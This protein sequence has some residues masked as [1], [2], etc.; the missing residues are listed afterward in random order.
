MATYEVIE[1]QTG[2]LWQGGLDALPRSLKV[3]A[4]LCSVDKDGARTNLGVILHQDIVFF[5]LQWAKSVS[6]DP[7]AEVL[8]CFGLIEQ[9]LEDEDSVTRAELNRAADA[10]NAAA[11]A[12]ATYAAATAAYA[13]ANAAAAAANAAYAAYAA[14][15]AAAAYSAA[16]NAAYA[17]QGQ[18]IV[19]YYAAGTCHA[20]YVSQGQMIVDYYASLRAK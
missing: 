2:F 17:S 11:N 15:N 9:W 8:K 19:D 14:T 4:L 20:T 5:A 12:A 7:K 16:A 13:A 10:A 6:K 3:N 1:P 18:M